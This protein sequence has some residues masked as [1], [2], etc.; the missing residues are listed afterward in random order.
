MKRPLAYI[1]LF[2]FSF[3]WFCGKKGPILPPIVKAPQKIETLAVVQRGNEFIISWKNP[4]RYIDGSP[5]TEIK[6][7]EI[8]RLEETKEKDQPLTPV[9]A[10]RFASDSSILLVIP[11]DKLSEYLSGEDPAAAGFEYIFAFKPEDVATKRF[12]IGLKVKD[13]RDK[14]SEFSPFISLEPKPFPAPPLELSVE[15]NKDKI[16]V[17]WKAAEK[18]EEQ[19]AQADAKGYNVFRSSGEERPQK[20]N[21]L[22]LTGTSYEDKGFS[23]GARYRYFIRATASESPPFLESA[24]SADFEILAA[25][26]FPPAPPQGLSAIAGENRVSLSWDPNQEPDLAGYKVWRKKRSETEY[27]LLTPELL[28]ENSYADSSLE[29]NVLY[30]YTVTAFDISENQS[31]EAQKVSVILSEGIHENLPI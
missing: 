27:Q 3:M 20:L 14:N 10:S 4:S 15:V 28:E 21:A 25:D 22:P 6:E 12:T 19:T 13:N 23:F 2:L 30:D 11:G 31:K 29:K 26:T 5:L 16:L 7:V 18:S 1:L 9:T 24:D 17:T 8:W